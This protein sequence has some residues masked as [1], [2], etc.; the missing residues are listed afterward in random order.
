[1]KL[2]IYA[3]LLLDALSMPGAATPQG[4][5]NPGLPTVTI[6]ARLLF[7]IGRRNLLCVFA[8]LASAAAAAPAVQ[9]PPPP[10]QERIRHITAV[11][12]RAKSCRG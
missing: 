7:A 6:S 11:V 1:M 2:P 10:A 5:R 9:A 8:A 4:V 12:A 3:R